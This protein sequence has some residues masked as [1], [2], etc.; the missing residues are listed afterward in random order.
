MSVLYSFVHNINSTYFIDDL[1]ESSYH[2]ITLSIDLTAADE[3]VMESLSLIDTYIG[4]IMR[5]VVCFSYNNKFALDYFFPDGSDDITRSNIPMIFPDTPSDELFLKLLVRKLNAIVADDVII[6][7]AT[8][9]SFTPEEI[10]IDYDCEYEVL[11]TINDMV[12]EFAYEDEPWWDRRDFDTFDFGATSQEELDMV[13]AM[14]AA[15]KETE[16]EDD[17]SSALVPEISINDKIISLKFNTHVG[18]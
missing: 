10:I 2:K 5:Y 18:K 6:C 9:S 17:P 12:G 15:D 13:K 14:E 16:E 7:H 1:I 4:E 11:P 8:M 3:S